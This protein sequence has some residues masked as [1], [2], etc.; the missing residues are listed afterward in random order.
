MKI[1]VIGSRSLIVNDIEKYLPASADE[2]VSGGA[3]GIDECAREYA[4]KNNIKLTE[5]LP[6]YKKY[7]AGAPLKRNIKIIDYSDIVIAFWDRTSRGTSFVISE[8][9]KRNKKLIIYRLDPDN[10]NAPS[11]EGA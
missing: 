3:K 6:E 5:F 8:C 10:K 9:K 1:A 2:I 4:I 7:R 11:K